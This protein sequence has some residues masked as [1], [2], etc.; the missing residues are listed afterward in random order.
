MVK[1]VIFDM[2]GLL[3]DNE[4]IWRS[5]HKVVLAKKGFTVT[6]DDVR[7]M[8][9]KGTLHIVELWRQRFKGWGRQQDADIC[10]QIFDEVEKKVEHEGIELPGVTPLI[11]ELYERHIPLAVASSSP[12]F[13]IKMTLK[14]LGIDAFIPTLHSGVDE[15][16]PKPA[17][18]V[19]LSTA[20]SLGIAPKEC[21][22]FEDSPSGIKS[23]KAA[24]MICVAVPEP[25]RDLSPFHGADFVIPSLE[26]FDF[27]LLL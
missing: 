1:A 15:A 4:S 6:E 9:G 23:A 11:K 13:L 26:E 17:P 5:A 22:V 20:K 3:I 21:L 27:K 10:Q 2:D 12:L 25:G 24:G 7:E 16:H 14:K 8:A 19:Y 18:D